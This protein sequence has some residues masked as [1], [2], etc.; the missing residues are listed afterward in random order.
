MSSR[1]KKKLLLA[2]LGVIE[3]LGLA[4]LAAILCLGSVWL[5]FSYLHPSAPQTPAATPL[6]ALEPVQP[7]QPAAPLGAVVIKPVNVGT[8]PPGD[9]PP[10]DL[11]TLRE[12]WRYELDSTG[13]VTPPLVLEDG[14][15]AV[16]LGER[17]LLAIEPDG[18]LRYEYQPAEYSRLGHPAVFQGLAVMLMVDGS[19]VKLDGL[20]GEISSVK[21]DIDTDLMPVASK[22]GRV[23]VYG[24]DG[25]LLCCGRSD[26]ALWSFDTG[27]R[28]GRQLPLPLSEG[29]VL[30]STEDGVLFHISGKGQLVSRNDLQ[31]ETS[32]PWLLDSKPRKGRAGAVIYAHQFG[33]LL[34]LRTDGKLLWSYGLGSEHQGGPGIDRD[35]RV[36]SSNKA[37]E[38]FC[39]SPDGSLVWRKNLF[40]GIC[41]T[42]QP[43]ALPGGGIAFYSGDEDLRLLDE[44]GQPLGGAPD[45]TFVSVRPD[46]SLV[47]RL[48]DIES[49]RKYIAAFAVDRRQ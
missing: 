5:Y 49:G 37:G 42:T 19:L 9:P 36:Y 7:L 38:I 44:A 6:T 43:L 41:S 25:K 40:N 20:G 46:G 11:G 33:S 32:N 31:L 8:P 39:L 27:G 13:I 48:N 23:Y 17:R 14:S 24:K 3:T 34:A 29:A 26:R 21:L 12:L 35:G 18:K 16:M 28:P 45:L 15:V 47:A 1:K 22:N 30:V 2:Q 10:A 4:M